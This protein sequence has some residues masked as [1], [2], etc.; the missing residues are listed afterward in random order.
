MKFGITFDLKSEQELPAGAP[1]DLFEEFDDPSTVKAIA[2]VL[3]DLGHEVVELGNGRPMIERLLKSPP[4]FVFNFAEGQGIGRSR[5]S[6]V[7][8]ILE[9]LGIP[10]SGSDPATLAVCLDK[11]WARRMVESVGV[12]VPRALTISF[13]AEVH[14]DLRGMG[15]T[16]LPEAG[17]DLPLI[18]KPV[19]EGSSKGIRNKCLI[20][21]A[22]DFGPVAYELWQQYRQTVLVE[23]FID[24]E[25][26]T[27]GVWGNNPPAVIGILRVVPRNPGPFIYSLEVKR[28]YKELVDYE[29]PAFISEEDREAVE[30]SALLA[31]DVLGCRDICRMDFRLRDGV[32]YFLEANPL[33]GLNPV[34]GDIVLLAKGMGIS[35]AQLVERI[36]TAA[37]ERQSM[38][39]ASEKHR[40]LTNSPEIAP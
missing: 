16:I 7:P 17:L 40:S 32:P 35:H 36:V 29:C 31:F 34:T 38:N 30:E 6:Q 20:E 27:V 10:Y 2:G 8:A 9:T 28:N 18:V 1:D 4:D 11:D 25:E 19:C 12:Q 22:E 33:P 37:M 15:E 24:G 3:R 5:E 26:L 13:G 23:E 39:G 14:A 21:R